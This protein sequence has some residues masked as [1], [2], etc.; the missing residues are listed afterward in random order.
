MER[1]Y[2]VRVGSAGPRERAFVVAAGDAGSRLDAFLA[3]A[4]GCSRAEV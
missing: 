4:L 3:R 2:P 1:S